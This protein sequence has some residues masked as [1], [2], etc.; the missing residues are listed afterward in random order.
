[1]NRYS[2]ETRSK[3]RALR[4]LGKT[5]GE[6]N[7]EMGTKLPKSSLYELCKGVNLP[8]N[9][10]EK[11]AELNYKNVGKARAIALALNKIKRKEFFQNLKL[12]NQPLSK[13]IRDKEIGKIALATLCLGEASKYSATSRRFCLGSSDP[14]IIMI[15]LG[16]LKWC[17]DFDLNKVRAT[18]QCRA[19]QDTKQLELYW[20][21][22][23]K[24][25]ERLFYKP[26]IDPRT[27]GKPTRKKNYKGVLRVDYFDTRV[28][29]ELESL[30]DLIYN[31]VQKG[32]W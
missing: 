25:P 7:R 2:S 21:E 18:L 20:R 22:V 11:I 27:V 4:S 23:T 24:I 26:L 8:P 1:M 5:Y 28:Q 6:I 9:Y 10:V 13:R 3:I 15:F 17:F 31:Q 32:L 12:V 19:D 29:L 16:L 30:A 14:R